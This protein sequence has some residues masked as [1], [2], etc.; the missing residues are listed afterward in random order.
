[1]GRKD[2][3]LGSEQEEG[4]DHGQV[5]GWCLL[6]HQRR[7]GGVHRRDAYWLWYAEPSKDGFVKTLQIW[8][9]SPASVEQP[10]DCCQM[11]SRENPGNQESNRCESMYVLC[12]LILFLQSAR[13]QPSLVECISEIHVSW[14]RYG[15]TPGCTGCE[16]AMAQVP[17]RDHT[18]RCRTRIIKAMSSDVAFAVRVRDA[19]ERR[20][21]PPL[22]QN[23][24]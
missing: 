24:T 15:Y 8:S 18:E 21:R 6:G 3:V 16:A 20:S 5:F 4:A 1:M 2:L 17:S 9:L 13:S 12:I 7:I 22:M 19:H 11:T 14:A 10:R 23:Q